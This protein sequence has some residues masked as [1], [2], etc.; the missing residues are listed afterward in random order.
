MWWWLLYSHY[1]RWPPNSRRVSISYGLLQPFNYLFVLFERHSVCDW[2]ELLEALW[3]EICWMLE[4]K[5][6]CEQLCVS[7]NS[8]NDPFFNVCQ[9]YLVYVGY[10]CFT[11]LFNTC[12]RQSSLN[13]PFTCDC[14]SCLLSL[15]IHEY[16]QNGANI[17]HALM[18]GVDSSMPFSFIF[19]ICIWVI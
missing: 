18:W 17:F 2:P 8:V 15:R 10:C 3:H 4:A 5:I 14:D 16:K 12:P 6:L 7:T 9:I 11:G 19:V 13:Y 1:P